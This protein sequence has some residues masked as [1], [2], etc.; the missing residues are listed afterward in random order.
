MAGAPHSNSF[1]PT[2]LCANGSVPS[3]RPALEHPSLPPSLAPAEEAYP[4]LLASGAAAGY[5][6]GGE[7]GS[8][9]D[10]GKGGGAAATR[11]LVLGRESAC[12][13]LSATLEGRVLVDGGAPRCPHGAG[14]CENYRVYP[15]P[16]PQQSANAMALWWQTLLT[17]CGE[18]GYSVAM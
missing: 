16:S 4:Y 12:G 6:A 2:A 15:P 11:T 1:W 7:G 17:L 14:R 5:P 3:P 9:G 13:L 18:Q 8:E 10:G